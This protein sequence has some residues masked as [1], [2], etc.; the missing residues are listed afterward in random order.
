MRLVVGQMENRL[1]DGP[2]GIVAPGVESVVGGGQQRNPVDL[3]LGKQRVAHVALD[4]PAQVG[5]AAGQ[6][7]E[8]QRRGAVVHRVVVPEKEAMPDNLAVA[9]GGFTRN[10]RIKHFGA[11]P[12]DVHVRMQLPRQDLQVDARLR[13][14]PSPA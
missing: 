1:A 3:V 9:L 10:P 8:V 7:A 13:A 4:Y 12:E 2:A 14:V 11:G 6:G 5:I